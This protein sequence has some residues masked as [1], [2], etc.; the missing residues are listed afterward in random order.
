MNSIFF[1][2]TAGI[3]QLLFLLIPVLLALPLSAQKLGTKR[4]AVSVQTSGIWGNNNI[5]TCWENPTPANSPGRQWVQEAVKESWEKHS[6]IRFTGWQKCESDSECIRILINDEGPHVKRLGKHLAGKAN[7]MVLNFTFEN[8]NPACQNN[9]EACIRSIAVHEFGHAL[10]IT[11]E[12]NRGD[13]PLECRLMCQGTIGDWDVTSYDMNSVMNYCNDI[14]N[15]NGALSVTDILGLQTLYGKPS[16]RDSQF[17]WAILNRESSGLQP[18]VAYALYNLNHSEVLTY[19]EREYGI[20]LVWDA[21]IDMRNI[22]FLRQSSSNASLRSGERLAIH[23]ENGGYLKYESRKYGINIVWSKE[24]VYEWMLQNPKAQ[25]LLESFMPI[26][27]Y[28]VAEKDYLAYC[29]REYG[30]NLKWIGD[31]ETAESISVAPSSPAPRKGAYKSLDHYWSSIR[32]DNY[33]TATPEAKK[34]A[35]ATN[36]R[37]VRTDGYVLNASASA[38]GQAVP[39]YLYY[40]PTRK[41]NFTTAS[42]EGIRAA[43]AAG[44]RKVRVE[45]YVLKTVRPEYQHL[46]RPLWLYYHDTRKDNFTIATPE[47]RSTAEAGGYRKVR[48]EGYVKIKP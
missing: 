20:N 34:G 42:P 35:L 11:H 3:T 17:D 6:N 7:G 18:G 40:D 8:W 19:K 48:M 39:L 16:E 10:S 13:A 38:E 28:N 31:C 25:G 36:Y 14:W 46:Y 9:A 32:T 22:K 4:S 47:G 2:R 15:N 30:I 44:Y 12:Q 37:H 27:I 5:C 21:N 23:V 43:E 26:S 1:S 24:P 29:E 41:D 33:S 45:G